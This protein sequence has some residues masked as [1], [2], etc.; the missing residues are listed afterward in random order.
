V[1]DSCEFVQRDVFLIL[2]LFATAGFACGQDARPSPSISSYCDALAGKTSQSAALSQV[3]QFALSVDEQLPNVICSQETTRYKKG[4]HGGFKLQDV[5]TAEVSYTDGKEHYRNVTLNGVPMES[6]VPTQAAGWSTGEFGSALHDIFAPQSMAEFKFDR[7]DL[8]RSAPVLIFQ[9]HVKQ[10]NNSLW[11]L[12]VGTFKSFPGYSGSVWVDEATSHLVRMEMG[13]IEIEDSFPLRLVNSVI[14]YAD[15]QLGD[16]TSFD[17]PVKSETLACRQLDRDS[18]SITDVGA[19]CANNKGK[20][21]FQNVLKF[22]NW[23]KFG[24]RARILSDA[25]AQAPQTMTTGYVPAGTQAQL[26]LEESQKEYARLTDETLEDERAATESEQRQTISELTNAELERLAALMR[27]Q[28]QAETAAA[29]VPAQNPSNPPAEDQPAAATIKVDVRLVLVRVVARDNRGCA[30]GNLKKEDFQLLDKGEPQVISQFSVEQH[31]TQETPADANSTDTPAGRPVESAAPQ[32]YVAYVFDDVHLTFGD[33]AHARDSFGRHLASLQPSD[34]AAIVTTSG[35]I[36]LDFTDDRAKLRQT[37][38]RLRSNP[39][40]LAR[41]ACPQISYY[42]ADLVEN[43]HDPQ[44]LQDVA[45]DAAACGGMGQRSAAQAASAA[46]RQVLAIGEQESRVSLEVLK[47]VVQGIATLPGLRSLILVSPGFLTPDLEYEYSEIVDRA[48]RAQIVISALDAR[49]VYV[50]IRG[51]DVS[52]RNASSILS[53]Y[54][55]Q[56]AVAAS[57]ILAALADG[58]G[59]VFVH[60]SNDLTAGFQRV[61]GIPEYSYLLGFAPQDLK[62]DGKFH[63]LKI[64]LANGQ[65]LTIQAR[66]GYYAPSRNKDSSVPAK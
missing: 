33:L 57:D 5:V 11:H 52:A 3:C 8:L 51:G 37:A 63:A 25:N 54:D 60:G 40:T 13:N 46:A 44:A 29:A 28:R 41:S 38:E 26:D 2:L 65:K 35:K 62:A 43:K 55:T 18:C 23:R 56:E 66:S 42:L 58:T 14:D 32:R 22:G 6:G 34:R 47:S 15:V 61:A 4:E 49:G 39:S 53:R 36:V 17:L 1:G 64:K 48:V 45:R 50:S 7:K 10:R 12:Q 9:F 59:G 21:C 16:G 19:S 27:S 30:V 20:F 31:E 24:A